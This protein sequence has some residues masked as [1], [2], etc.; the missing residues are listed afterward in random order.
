MSRQTSKGLAPVMLVVGAR[1]SSSTSTAR[2]WSPR[3]SPAFR[4]SGSVGAP[5]QPRA[6][7]GPPDL[8]TQHRRRAA[9]DAESRLRPSALLGAPAMI[10]RPDIA[11]SHALAQTH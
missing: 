9:G 7:P 1:T 3:R 8:K 2:A 11:S 6:T 5:G 4:T 10:R